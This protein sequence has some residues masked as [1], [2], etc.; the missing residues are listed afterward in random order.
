MATQVDP[1]CRGLSNLEH[2]QYLATQYIHWMGKGHQWWYQD[3]TMS[4]STVLSGYGY[5]EINFRWLLQTN[6]YVQSMEEFRA[7]AA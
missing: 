4:S 1:L 5:V 2:Q 6:Q 3:H 7:M